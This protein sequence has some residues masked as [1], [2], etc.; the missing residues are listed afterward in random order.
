MS[1]KDNHDEFEDNE[2]LNSD[3]NDLNDADENFGLPD[4]DYSPIDENAQESEAEEIPEEPER[5]EEQQENV[6]YAEGDTVYPSESEDQNP[7][8]EPAYVPG[9]YVPPK[10]NSAVGKVIAIAVVVILAAVGVWYFG[11]YQP[12]KKAEE[13][14]QIGEQQRIERQKEREATAKAE[15]ERLAREQAQRD[16]EA[17]K[18]AAAESKPETGT[19]ETISSRTG[20]YYIIIAS[21]I[22]ED[23]AM[24]HA[25]KLSKKGVSTSI[26]K[27]YGKV[28][29]HRIAVEDFDTWASAQNRAN[30]LKAEYGEGVWVKKY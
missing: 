2:N 13:R 9:S 18:L 12:Q 11:F 22:D 4:I 26:I 8:E 27:P 17:A 29:F 25:K 30:E 21:A 24:D 7:P 19:I 15:R 16:E 23:L 20:R 28:K 6:F 14:A 10:D 5:I 1:K 3:S